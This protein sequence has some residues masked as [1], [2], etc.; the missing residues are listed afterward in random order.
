MSCC[1][2]RP[3]CAHRRVHKSSGHDREMRGSGGAHCPICSR[4]IA[5]VGARSNP[6]LLHIFP[7]SSL[8]VKAV[9]LTIPLQR[10]CASHFVLKS[11]PG[12]LLSWGVFFPT[13]NTHITLHAAHHI[14][15]HTPSCLVSSVLCLVCLCLTRSAIRTQ[16]SCGHRG[17]NGLTI[18]E[19]WTVLS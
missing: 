2:I 17:E 9:C 18:L 15:T 10:G 3:C 5:Q 1:S 19:V 12:N 4:I 11:L 14:D 16:I 13:P 6:Q 7:K 8:F